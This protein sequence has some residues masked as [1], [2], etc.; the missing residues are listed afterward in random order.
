MADIHRTVQLMGMY[1]LKRIVSQDPERH[2]KK[3]L[4]TDFHPVL[5]NTDP[6]RTH[7][8]GFQSFTEKLK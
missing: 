3:I 6:S 8:K 5:A 2:N 7:A 1:Y 4:L